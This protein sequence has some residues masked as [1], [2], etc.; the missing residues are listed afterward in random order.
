MEL[1]NVL[2]DTKETILN[3]N[4]MTLPHINELM[5]YDY[6]WITS[7]YFC[8]SIYYKEE[9]IYKLKYLQNSGKII[10]VDEAYSYMTNNLKKRNFKPNITILSPNKAI[11]INCL[12]FSVIIYDQKYD[13]IFNHWVDVI[14]GNLS[15]SNIEAIRHFLSNN[16]IECFNKHLEFIN[17]A[18]NE[19]KKVLYYYPDFKILGDPNGSMIMI[20]NSKIKFDIITNIKFYSDLM[21]STNGYILPGYFHDYNDKNGFCFRINLCLFDKKN[22][23]IILKNILDYLMKY[24]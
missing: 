19:V 20:Q 5:E 12:K 4:G 24:Y 21:M 1:L 13:N 23:I 14:H 18:L 10:I 6:I 15:I 9:D 7:P 17:S 3:C 8:S 11:G 16:Y 2:Y 22:F